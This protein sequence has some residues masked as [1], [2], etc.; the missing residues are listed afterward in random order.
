MWRDAARRAISGKMALTTSDLIV[1]SVLLRSGPMHGYEVWQRLANSDVQDWASVSRAQ[2]YYSL[3]KLLGTEYLERVDEDQPSRGPERATVSAT[4]AAH[5]AVADALAKPFWTKRDP[6]SPFV[7]WSALALN[8]DLKVTAEQIAR[9]RDILEREIERE[10]AT[11]EALSGLTDKDAR[12]GHA[13]TKM[14]IARMRAEIDEI[15][16]LENA[17]KD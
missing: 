6:P 2:V 4:C 7:T 1:L 16:L 5:E 15:D 13:L 11:V 3:R 10:E 12:L 8:A 14:S 9:R 17:L